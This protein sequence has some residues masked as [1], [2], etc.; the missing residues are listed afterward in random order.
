M[1]LPMTPLILVSAD[2]EK[3]SDYVKNYIQENKISGSYIF[4]IFPKNKE[5][6]IDQIRE[7]KRNVIYSNN[8]NQLFILHDFDKSSSEAQNAFLKTLEE[9]QE[10][11]H[12]ILLVKIHHRLA[13]TIIS[14]SKIIVLEA[15]KEIALDP[16]FSKKLDG[17]LES[18]NLKILADQTFQTREYPESSF[19]FDRL[20]SYFRLRLQ[21]DPKA[22][23]ILRETLNLKSLVEHNNVDAQNAIDFLLL[24]ISSTYKQS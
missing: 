13:P 11:I 18:P 16:Q 9:H 23:K 15:E 22:P 20:I 24:Q 17:L 1:Q 7:V 3:I 5:L 8:E 21:A 19:L 10:N 6:S 2:A 4:D 14:R 12:F